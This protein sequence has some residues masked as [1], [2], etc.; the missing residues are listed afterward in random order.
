[1]DT[2]GNLLGV[3]VLPADIADGDG[4]RVLLPELAPRLERLARIWT[5]GAY[6]GIVA[7]AQERFGWTVE[8]V[9]KLAGQMGFVPLPKRWLVE[10]TFG[11][12]GR[13]RRLARDYEFWACNA[14]SV[15]YIASIHRSLKRL[16]APT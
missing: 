13:N 8:V 11:C 3:K 7:W 15:V 12:L 10:Q 14:E 2:L 9:S 6:G 16:T 4:A 1:M 5:D